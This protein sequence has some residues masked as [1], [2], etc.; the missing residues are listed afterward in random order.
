[1]GTIS[2]N[3]L[4]G[5]SLI[6]G[7]IVALIGY[8]LQPG[9]TFID[10]ANPGETQASLLAITSNGSLS[11][12]TGFVVAIGL[13]IFLYGLYVFQGKLSENG[14]GNA[15][16]RFGLQFLLF[17]IIG[18]VISTGL[19]NAVA[20]SDL[21]KAAEEAA[22]GTLYAATLGIGTTAGVLAGLGFLLL[23]LAVSTRD[24][25]NKVFALVAAVVAIIAIIVTIIGGIDL[26][27]LQTMQLI[28]G[29]SY[30]IHTIW[31]ITIGLS[32]I[33]KA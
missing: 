11:Q 29:I 21:T 2:V 10:T 18:W 1:M 27:Q 24:D 19:G 9:G 22:A 20:G 4:G 15:L 5:L 17:G 8:F 13:L 28:G 7:P 26:K 6:L 31:T 33:K 3:K 16:S 32:L 25:Y 12:I 30:I 23:A 14:N